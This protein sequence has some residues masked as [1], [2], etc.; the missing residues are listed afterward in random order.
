MSLKHNCVIDYLKVVYAFLIITVHYQSVYSMEGYFKRGAI[1]VEFFYILLGFAMAA[2]STQIEY[3]DLADE[4]LK[5]LKERAA[6]ILYPYVM[7]W[8]I[9]FLCY[10]ILNQS[11]L[12]EWGTSL[13][14]GIP[15]LLL[16]HSTGMQMMCFLKQTWFI[17]ALFMTLIIVYPLLLKFKKTYIYIVSPFLSAMILG[18]IRKKHGYILWDVDAMMGFVTK[19]F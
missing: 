1:G 15:E 2:K 11:T 19:G 10:N 8:T 5:Y 16:L 13:L 14:L 3:T 17:S 9:S 6:R 12:H 4:T 7:C 18:Y